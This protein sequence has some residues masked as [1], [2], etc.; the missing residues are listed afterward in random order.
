MGS[1]AEEGVE[2]T[3][4]HDLVKEATEWLKLP[5]TIDDEDDARM[6]AEA[7]KFIDSLVTRM[8]TALRNTLRTKESP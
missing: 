5:W 4:P 3:D 2:S 8:R 7:R 6:G 1:V